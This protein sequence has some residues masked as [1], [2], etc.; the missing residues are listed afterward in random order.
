MR[1]FAKE[2]FNNLQ[3]KKT[4]LSDKIENADSSKKKTALGDELKE[5]KL[6]LIAAKAKLEIAQVELIKT[7]QED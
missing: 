3:V 4:E 6:D 7:T 2:I 5:I 1:F